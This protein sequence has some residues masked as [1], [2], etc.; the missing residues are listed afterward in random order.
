M[1]AVGEGRRLARSE[2]VGYLGRAGLAAQGVCFGI[3]GALAVGLALGAGGTTTDPQG[4]FYALARQGWTKLLLILLCFGFAGYAIWRLAQALFDR[5]G[6]GTGAGGLGRRAIQ[7]VQGLAYVALTVG[8][9]R[10]LTG[11]RQGGGGERH[12]AA[13][14]LGWPGGQELVAAVGVVLLVSAVVTVYWA[15]SRRFEESLATAEMGEETRR[16]VVAA[17]V[18]GLCSLAVVLAIVGWFLLKAALDFNRSAPVGVGGALAKLAHAPYGGWL[19]GVTAAGLVVFA[20]FDLL[21]A[22]Y[23]E[24]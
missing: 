22:R 23:H 18:A 14:M 5:G 7:L 15:L 13:G 19:L 3:I 12:A 21:Q 9:V 6:M 16:L 10:T 24:A 1:D 17:G 8:A 4:V 2:W 11:G 20:L